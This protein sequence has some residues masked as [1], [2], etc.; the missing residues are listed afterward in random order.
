[1]NTLRLI[2]REIITIREIIVYFNKEKQV[3]RCRRCLCLE[4]CNDF[5]GALRKVLFVWHVIFMKIHKLLFHFL[6]IIKVY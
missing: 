1:L 5:V 3:A 6:A 2:K 4:Q